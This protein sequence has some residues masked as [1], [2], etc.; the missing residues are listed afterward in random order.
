MTITFDIPAPFE[1]ELRQKLGDLTRAARE[2]FLIEGYRRG[3]ISLGALAQ[4]QG[5]GVL[6][7]DAWLAKRGVSMNYGAA[8]LADDLR[9]ADEI[10]A[11]RRE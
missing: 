2:A 5:M 8:E 10:W 9:T 11:E 4:L 3:A 7:A 1:N 6:E